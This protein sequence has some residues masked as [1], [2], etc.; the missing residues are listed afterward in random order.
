ML[1]LT[2]A[3]QCP[4]LPSPWRD[5]VGVVLDVEMPHGSSERSPLTLVLPA[6]SASIPAPGRACNSIITTGDGPQFG[7]ISSV[8]KCVW[9]SQPAG[10]PTGYGPS[11]TVYGIIVPVMM[12]SR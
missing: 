6:P 9:L 11:D 7:V 3:S 2:G 4:V 12:V 10:W 5:R 1:F 8:H